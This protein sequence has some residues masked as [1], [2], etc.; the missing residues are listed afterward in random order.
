[1]KKLV[2]ESLVTIMRILQSYVTGFLDY[3]AQDLETSIKN[4][5]SL[6]LNVYQL[7]YPLAPCF[8]E[9]VSKRN[10]LTKKEYEN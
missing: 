9:K 6:Q 1:M 3:F 4:M 7:N 5:L 2:D 10:N 8:D